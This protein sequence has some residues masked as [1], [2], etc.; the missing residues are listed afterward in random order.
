MMMM[1]TMIINIVGV[2]V[3]VLLPDGVAS[4]KCSINQERK[5]PM[6]GIETGSMVW[7]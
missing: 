5:W 4:I 6:N 3:L 1:M 7:K 2:L